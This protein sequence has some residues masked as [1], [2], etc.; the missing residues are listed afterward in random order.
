[1]PIKR[2]PEEKARIQLKHEAE[3]ELRSKGVQFGWFTNV[4]SNFNP[5]TYEKSL[6]EFN[7][8]TLY[9]HPVRG[10][11]VIKT[12]LGDWFYLSK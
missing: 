8:C 6:L 12:N 7:S 9:R 11:R 3:K 2:S 10:T 5:K 1:M 4:N